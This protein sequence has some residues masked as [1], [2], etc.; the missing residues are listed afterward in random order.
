MSRSH[1]SA[2]VFIVASCITLMLV[3]SAVSASAEGIRTTPIKFKLGCLGSGR[4]DDVQSYPISKFIEVVKA[5]T[6]GMIV[7]EYF[8][9]GQLGGEPE[10]MDQVLSDTLDFGVLSANVLATVWPAF[11]VYNLPFAFPSLK[12]FWA[13]CGADSPEFMK[14]I[15]AAMNDSGKA[16]FVSSF[17]A[18]FRGCQNTKRVL[19]SPKDFKGIKFRVMAG[20]IFTDIFRSLGASTATVPFAELYTGL[21]QGV[22]HGE[23]IG[24]SMFYDTKLYEV[25]KYATQFNITQ[26]VNA[27]IVSNAAWAKLSEAERKIVFE[28][29]AEAEKYSYE[30]VSKMSTKYFEPLQK[31]GVKITKYSDLTPAEIKACVDAVQPVWKKYKPI[32]GDRV[33]TAFTSARDKALASK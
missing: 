8:P 11:Y 27:L 23:D 16:H 31:L 21:Q 10:M 18:E 22:I 9:D 26:T 14:A 20:Q 2:S 6:N 17:S 7:F 25:E 28:A 33:Y 24:F 32:I 12:E 30:S 1:R 15:S 19:R 3:F 4:V 5:R 29:A 13:T